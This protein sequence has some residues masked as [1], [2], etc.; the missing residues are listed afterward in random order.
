M[1]HM[2]GPL[3]TIDVGSRRVETESIDDVLGSFIGG[4]GVATRLAH[5]RIPF[6]ADPLG[7]ENRL[8]FTTGPMQASSMS[9]T[10]RTSATAVSPLTDGLLSANA[11][12][13]V[14]RNLTGTRNAVVELVG[15]SDDPLMIHVREDGVTFEAVPHLAGAEVPTVTEYVE[16]EHDLGPENVVCIGP[17]GENLV[18]FACIMTSETRAF[19]RGGLGAVM[20]SKNVKAI[21][22]DGDASPDVEVDA[23]AATIHREAATSDHIMK[24]QGTASVTDLANEIGS[25]ST[26]YFE[27]V[28]YEAFENIN[29]DAVEA[30]KYKKGTCSQCAFAC[31]LPTRDEASGVETEGPEFETIMAFGGNCEVDDIVSIMQSNQLCDRLGMDTISCGNAVA[32]YLKANDAFGDD[33]LIHETVRKIAAREGDGDLLAEGIHRFHDELGVEDWTV[34]GLSFSAHDGRTLNG[35]G[36]GFATANRGGD[37]M[38]AT[39]YAYEYPLVDASEAFEPSG[40]SAAKARKL[41]ELENKRALEDCGVVCRFSRGMMTAERFEKLFDADFDD[42]LDVGARV[43]ELER[44]FNNQ[45]GFDR[46]DDTLP[47]DLPDFDAALDVYYETRGWTDRGIVPDD[48]LGAV[49]AD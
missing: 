19:G 10:G 4:R 20:G 22:F 27:D 8:Y 35:Q 31:K 49:S 44:H 41:V 18:R 5:E 1:L 30:K 6:D 2:E 3:L 42:L 39:F 11:G 38:Y 21:T 33:E 7:P 17:A 48:E 12:G 32:A 47:Y 13:F 29:G 37:H 46:A 40:L 28:S 34:K 16:T 15:E 43:V 45:R 23:E 25:F 26:R 14:S 24:R 9:F 36:L